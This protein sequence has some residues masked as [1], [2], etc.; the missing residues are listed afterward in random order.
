MRAPSVR[1]R[2]RV[3]MSTSA[4]EA[5]KMIEGPMHAGKVLRVDP[6]FHAVQRCGRC[7]AYQPAKPMLAD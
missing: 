7:C 1:R 2:G 6:T 5:P 3:S 4:D